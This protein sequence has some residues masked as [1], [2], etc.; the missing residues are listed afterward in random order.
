MTDITDI[1]YDDIISFLTSNN[2]KLYKNK[3]DNYDTVFDIIQ[4]RKYDNYPDSIIDWIIAYNLYNEDRDI[5]HYTRGEINLM[6]KEELDQL[7][8]SLDIF[9]GNNIKQSITNVLKYLHKLDSKIIHSDI[10]PLILK[11]VD[12]QRILEGNFDDTTEI[13]KN[14]RSLRKFIYDN[15]ENI[16]RNNVDFLSVED[17]MKLNR[18]IVSFDKLNEFALSKETIKISVVLS[19]SVKYRYY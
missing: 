2:V 10:D 15:M 3:N 13:F 9:E 5:P 14:N 6:N 8:L 18:F 11:L 12:E 19:S 16:I 1:P 4:Q 7:A 17:L